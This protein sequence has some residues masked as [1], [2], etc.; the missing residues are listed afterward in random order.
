MASRDRPVNAPSEHWHR[1][2]LFDPIDA[3]ASA[4]KREAREAKFNIRVDDIAVADFISLVSNNRT[5]VCTENQILQYW[6]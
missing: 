2:G 6:R 4:L 5:A 3:A 1:L